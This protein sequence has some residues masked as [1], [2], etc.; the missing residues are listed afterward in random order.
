MQVGGRNVGRQIFVRRHLRVET[1]C[2]SNRLQTS[3]SRA[4]SGLRKAK[5]AQAVADQRVLEAASKTK[6]A[7]KRAK[8]VENLLAKER[9]KVK[10]AEDEVARV[11][12]AAEDLKETLRAKEELLEM[13]RAR[14]S[15]LA[16][17]EREK[18]I[19]EYRDSDEL[20]EEV[21]KHFEAEYDHCIKRIRELRPEYD[22]SVLE[23]AADEDV[24]EA[25][26]RADVADEVQD[27]VI[28]VTPG[29]DET[30]TTVASDLA[31]TPEAQFLKTGATLDRGDMFISTRMKKAGGLVNQE[32]AA[33][34]D[35]IQDIK[36]MQKSSI[37]SSIPSVGDA[38]EQ[39]LG[40][41]RTRRVCGIGTGPTSKS[42]WGSRSEQKLRQDNESLKQQIDALEERMKKIES[43]GNNESSASVCH[44][45]RKKDSLAGRRVRIL[46]FS[47]Q[48]V[49]SG[50]LMSNYNDNVKI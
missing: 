21:D 42:L 38:Y 15:R 20:N 34:I 9:L 47:G 25:Q 37:S 27:T 28:E 35:K 45:Q 43:G 14:S 12:K 22:L 8:T 6:E 16:E 39:V 3:M 29:A 10:R 19:A 30:A 48:V 23:D 40:R 7:E 32:S 33:M 18:I 49:A 2:R 1:S 17:E 4:L 11:T 26:D 41:D 31:T 13:A 36:L 50:I 46:N 5:K 24:G 44:A